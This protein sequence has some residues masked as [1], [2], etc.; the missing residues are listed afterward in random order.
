LG[1]GS[2]LSAAAAAAAAAATS[3]SMTDLEFCV[4]GSFLFLI[5]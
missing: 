1:R 3:P 2:S 4:L 5:K